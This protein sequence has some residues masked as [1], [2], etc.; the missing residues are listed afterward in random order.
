MPNPHYLNIVRVMGPWWYPRA[1]EV[2]QLTLSTGLVYQ[3]ASL[4]AFDSP[5]G[6]DVKKYFVGAEVSAEERLK[7]FKAATDLAVSSFGGRQELYERFYGGDPFA[8]RSQFW[9]NQFDWDGPMRL[10]DQCLA[11]MNLDQNKSR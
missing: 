9:F 11:A 10:V 7:L 1:R 8:L 3:P 5:I 2:L 6:P 4:S